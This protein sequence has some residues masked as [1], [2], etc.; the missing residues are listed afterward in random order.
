MHT[1]SEQHRVELLA[2]A[3]NIECLHA[4]VS[5]G[6]DA[7]YL[8][9]D[10]FNARRNADN[11][12]LDN[13]PE[14]C[15]YAHVRG[16]KIFLTLNIA[17]L[18]SEFERAVQLAKDAYR[19]GVD[20]LIVQDIGLAAEV[21]RVLPEAR[22]NISTQ[23]NIHNAAGIEFAWRIGARRVT[24]ARE[25]SLPEIAEL[26]AIAADFDMEVESFAHGALCICY[27]GQC[28]MSSMIGGRSA[29]RG[30]C[31]QPCRLPYEL[32]SGQSSDA[33]PPKS[34]HLLSPHDLCTIDILDQLVATGVSSLKIEGRMKSADYV[35]EVVSVYREVLDSNE[36]ATDV[37]R[38]RLAEAFSRGFTTAY[39]EGYRGN[40]IMGFDRP[41][42]RGVFVGRVVRV[43]DGY[44]D[45]ASEIDLH[46][47]DVL[48]FWTN[49]G[50][51]AATLVDVPKAFDGTVRI[52]I[53][54]RV[55]KGDRVFRVHNAATSFIDDGASPRIPVTGCV[56]LHIG[57]PA[58][59]VVS[60]VAR[61][62]S[63]HRG[64]AW[65]D[66]VEPARTR[67]V[68]VQ[69]VKDHVNRLGGTPFVFAASADNEVEAHDIALAVELDD[70]V[71]LGFSQLHRLRA[72]ALDE[73]KASLLAPFERQEPPACEAPSVLK[74]VRPKSCAV[75][76]WVTNPTCARTAKRAGADAIYVPALNYRR[77]Q[78]VMAGV[79]QDAPGQ[80]G[81]PSKC[82]LALP[83]IDH[84]PIGMAR[85]AQIEF[86]YWNYVKEGKLVFADNIAACERALAI[87]ARVELG[88]HVPVT[89]SASLVLLARM[90]VE[91]VWLSPEL[92]LGQ[93]DDL[94][95]TSPI[96]LGLV[97]SG[98]Q[99]LMVTEHCLLM[100]EG[101]CAQQCETCSRRAVEHHLLDR[102]VFEFPVITDMLGR[103]HLY[104]GIELD[105][106]ANMA[107]FI[108]IG[109]SA[110]MVDTTLM[111]KK[112][113][114][115]AVARALKA[116]ELAMLGQK[117]LAKRP[118]TTTGH[119]FRGVS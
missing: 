96:P 112:T 40:E 114:S 104:N 85:E 39:L 57:Q 13:L 28:L 55:V 81:Y 71:G 29:N 64:E 76:A 67:P 78:A 4:A 74:A 90:G 80:A 60:A 32:Q 49:R 50:N 79:R 11:F 87:G 94:A 82:V 1:S 20:A 61:D 72:Q 6:A 101:P 95:R 9:L 54:Q 118:N 75:V 27:S 16:V 53:S 86:D 56:S 41:N 25:L 116:R 23:M 47:G 91:R 73:L 62:G 42:N 35:Y 33:L 12:T 17:I 51:F 119:L 10:S 77:G 103:S 18:P 65:G 113:A 88:P 46:D 15:E 110:V 70:G 98:Q 5:A 92:T 99:E 3:G 83:T 93:I 100:G 115:D 44:A 102:K 52:E 105:T 38:A 36:P 48:E 108:D 2:P 26:A 97:I 43:G 24:L 8:G 19:A 22:L 58:H 37:H 31:A 66:T 14:A 21:A 117:G 68:S 34:E 111:D 59:M 107:D 7:V 106:V 109:L 63:L 69:D 84:D 30:L 89:N 45:V